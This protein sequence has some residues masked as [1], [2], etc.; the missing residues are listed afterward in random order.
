MC[1]LKEHYPPLSERIK[2]EERSFSAAWESNWNTNYLFPEESLLSRFIGDFN[3]EGL[4]LQIIQ[5]DD[6]RESKTFSI[7]GPWRSIEGI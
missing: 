6:N 7:H 4:S 1:T 3:I 5:K 2:T